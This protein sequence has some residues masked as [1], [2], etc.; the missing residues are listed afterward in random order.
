MCVSYLILNGLILA[1]GHEACL[2][3]TLP[4]RHFDVHTVEFRRSVLYNLPMEAWYFE[5]THEP[6]TYIHL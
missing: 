5:G 2:E 1:K 6:Y 3:I 4:K